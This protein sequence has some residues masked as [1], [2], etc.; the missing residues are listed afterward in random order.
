MTQVQR[1]DANGPGELL[2]V[3]VIDAEALARHG[4]ELLQAPEVLRLGHELGARHTGE[5]DRDSERKWEQPR[6]AATIFPPQGSTGN[7]RWD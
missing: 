1:R 3:A 2:R 7:P 5:R 4:R 6:H